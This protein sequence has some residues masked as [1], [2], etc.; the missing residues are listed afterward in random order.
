MPRIEMQI[1]PAFQAVRLS[2]K[3]LFAE[4]NKF[5]LIFSVFLLNA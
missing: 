3:E 4:R 5:E 2:E 1:L